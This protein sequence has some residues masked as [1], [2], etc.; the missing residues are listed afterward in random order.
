[1]K[2][3]ALTLLLAGTAWAQDDGLVPATMTTAQ[4]S[5]A[6]SLYREVR[7][8]T[9]TAQSVADSDAQL[10]VDMKRRIDAL[11]V[12]GLSNDDI[13][14]ELSLTYGDDIRL[15]PRR[16]ARTWALWAAPWAVLA[17]GLGLVLRRRRP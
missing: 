9:C 12:A 11:V 4:Q 7:C 17:I 1:M 3:L 2:V 14:D 6:E 5:R 15:R 8:P 16:E 10:S 13:L